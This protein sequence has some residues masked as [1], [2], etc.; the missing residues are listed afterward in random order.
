MAADSKDDGFD[1]ERDLEDL[2]MMLRDL[3]MQ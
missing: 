3:N 2:D 1:P